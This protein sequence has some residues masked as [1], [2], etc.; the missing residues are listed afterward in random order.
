MERAAKEAE[1]EAKKTDKE[2]K[3]PLKSKLRSK[4]KAAN[5][6]RMQGEQLEREGDAQDYPDQMTS[7][8]KT[9]V[10]EIAVVQEPW[11]APVARMW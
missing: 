5:T 11:R 2:A 1:K 3:K 6:D 10:Q 4:A 7:P 9:D 8:H